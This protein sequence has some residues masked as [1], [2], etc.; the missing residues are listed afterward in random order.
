MSNRAVC[1][2]LRRYLNWRRSTSA[3]T[4][5]TKLIFAILPR[6]KL[7]L[8]VSHDIAAKQTTSI[9]P[10]HS[11]RPHCRPACLYSPTAESRTGTSVVATLHTVTTRSDGA[12]EEREGAEASLTRPQTTKRPDCPHR[13][14]LRALTI[15]RDALEPHPPPIPN[16]NKLPTWA[17]RQR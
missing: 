5:L 9:H 7:V 12:R 11:S 16:K 13:L 2:P 4:I 1:A 3:L 6:W 15:P 17:S 8:M 10:P 14:L